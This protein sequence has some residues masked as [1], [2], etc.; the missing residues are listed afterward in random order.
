[1]YRFCFFAASAAPGD[2]RLCVAVGEVEHEA[3]ITAVAASNATR[4]HVG[5]RISA[6]SRSTA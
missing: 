1:M 3:T 2:F 6:V 4:R 5:R